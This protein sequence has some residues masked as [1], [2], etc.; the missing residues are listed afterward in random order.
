MSRASTRKTIDTNDLQVG[1]EQ[2]FDI[3]ITGDIDREDF[4]DQ[5]ETVDTPEWQDKARIL[6]FM[7][8]PVKIRISPETSPNAEQI[9]QVSVNGV[10]QFFVRDTIQTV[11]RKF[12]EVLARARPETL[13]TPEYIDSTG[14]R[15]T[16]IHKTYGLRYPFSVLHDPNPDGHV[17]LEAILREQ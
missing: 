11:K 15:A 5:F 9:F 16:R 6:A 8:E 2:S 17:W 12:V 10:N 7:E 3:P 1:Q 14:N 4:R 13:S